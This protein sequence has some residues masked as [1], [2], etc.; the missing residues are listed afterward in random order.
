[1]IRNRIIGTAAI[2]LGWINA[3]TFAVFFNRAISAA[4]LRPHQDCGQY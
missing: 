1:M 4:A 3:Q 2:N